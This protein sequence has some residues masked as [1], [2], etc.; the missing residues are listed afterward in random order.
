MI[1]FVACVQLCPPDIDML[2]FSLFNPI[3][4][5]KNIKDQESTITEQLTHIS[6]N[7][8]P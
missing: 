7:M 5:L 3:N 6:C 4:M 2:L 8:R 1:V